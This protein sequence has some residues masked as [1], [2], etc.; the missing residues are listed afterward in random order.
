MQGDSDGHMLVGEASGANKAGG[1]L[2]GVSPF[3]ITMGAWQRL[4][5]SA[6]A[7]RSGAV[8]SRVAAVVGRSLMASESRPFRGGDSTKCETIHSPPESMTDS[9]YPVQAPSNHNHP[10]D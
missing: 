5:T 3:A 1:C 10:G 9:I 4:T 6:S 8:R 7:L 2:E